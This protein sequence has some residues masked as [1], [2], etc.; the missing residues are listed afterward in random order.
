[1][2]KL[3][4]IFFIILFIVV[5]ISL[6]KLFIPQIREW[7]EYTHPNCK[8]NWVYEDYPDIYCSHRN[9]RTHKKTGE[10]QFLDFDGWCTEIKNNIIKC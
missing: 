7:Y 3:E 9:K 1:M 4:V 2:T 5:L 8:S 10:V 6:L